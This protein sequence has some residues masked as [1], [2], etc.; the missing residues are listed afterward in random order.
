[1]KNEILIHK[2]QTIPIKYQTWNMCCLSLIYGYDGFICVSIYTFTSVCF[3]FNDWKYDIE[4]K[5]SKP[6]K[7]GEYLPIVLRLTT[8]PLPHLFIFKIQ[9]R[10]CTYISCYQGNKLFSDILNYYTLDKS[11]LI[12][13]CMVTQ[14]CN[15]ELSMH[16]YAKYT[17]KYIL[18]IYNNVAE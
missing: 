5:I 14:F 7:H 4:R 18:H 9:L 15:L 12:F 6:S 8:N 2:H 13:W 10:M 17:K 1:M 16:Q 11:Y 3:M